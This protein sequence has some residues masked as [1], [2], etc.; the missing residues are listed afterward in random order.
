MQ[1]AIV[2]GGSRGLGKALCL[3][4]QKLNYNVVEFSRT[5]PHR[6]SH[7]LDLAAPEQAQQAVRTALTSLD[8]NTCT[9]LLVVNNAGSLA[10]IGPAWRK[11]TSDVLSNLNA[12]FCSAILLLTEVMQH[13]RATPC[14][15]VIINVS[16]GAALKGYAGW[17]LYC[18]SKAGMEGFIRGLA[19][20]E[21][22]QENPFLAVSVDPGVIDTD[23]QNLIRETSKADFPEVD[24]FIRRKQAGG[25]ATADSVASA[26]VRLVSSG[27][28]QPGGRYDAPAE[29]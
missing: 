4:L 5:A 27:S 13:F 2:T 23:M 25:L 17:S 9:D 16:S 15:K 11:P 8:P 22:H 1:L 12:N 26:I 18:A 3:Q 14:R 7:T 28:L 29:A 21:Q 20:E 10:P 19:V 24:R 6:F